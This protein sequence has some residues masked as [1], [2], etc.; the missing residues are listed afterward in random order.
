MPRKAGVSL[1]GVG[2]DFERLS[3]RQLALGVCHLGENVFQVSEN[4]IYVRNSDVC[5]NK[6]WGFL[7]GLLKIGER[8]LL[9]LGRKLS[10]EI[11]AL[12]ISLVRIR[13]NLAW[14][15]KPNLLLWT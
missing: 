8:F 9:V 15:G 6:V 11:L 10:E 3:D 1:A 2:V 7:D 14:T 13:V 4:L 5:Q 12:Q